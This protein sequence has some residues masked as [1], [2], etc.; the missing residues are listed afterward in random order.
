MADK[1]SNEE[2]NS[3][4]FFQSWLSSKKP[5]AIGTKF[6]ISQ[7]DKTITLIECDGYPKG[8]FVFEDGEDFDIGKYVDCKFIKVNSNF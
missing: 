5:M 6:T 3:I 4:T 2:Y 7:L 1:S 8:K